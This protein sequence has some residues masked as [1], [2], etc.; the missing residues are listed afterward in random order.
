MSSLN[1][2]D[3]ETRDV[4]LRGQVELLQSRRGYRTSVDAMA[5]AWFAAGQ[6]PHARRLLELGTGSGLVALLLLRT[7]NEAR[8][9]LVELQPTLGRRAERNLHLNGVADRAELQLADLADAPTLPAADLVVC[10]PPFRTTDRRTLPSHPERRLAHV[11][12]SADLGVFAQAAARALTT[13]GVSCWVFPWLER[14]RLL[15]ALAS[16]GLGRG[17]CHPLAHR[18]GD[19]APVRALVVAGHGAD[20]IVEG[21][22]RHL[23]AVDQ[24][25]EHYHFDIERFLGALSPR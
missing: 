24:R 11:E 3:D 16:A 17:T 23:H 21:E 19:A 4:L 8:A 13:E 1:P 18:E 6:A 5:L 9:H 12:S 10:N 2:S 7:L 22:W 15:H 20:G 25:D 14:A